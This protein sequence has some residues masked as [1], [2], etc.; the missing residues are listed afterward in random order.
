MNERFRTRADDWG[1]MGSFCGGSIK[2]DLSWIDKL[3]V[4]DLPKPKAPNPLYK[5]TNSSYGS[6]ASLA[7][8]PPKQFHLS[9]QFTKRF[10]PSPYEDTSLNTSRFRSVHPYP[11]HPSSPFTIY[12]P[13]IQSF[14]TQAL[15]VIRYIL[16][17]CFR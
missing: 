8:P 16:I 14:P 15:L 10:P 17:P 9:N 11:H 6:T 12:T 4:D 1:R 7:R 2:T 5:T 3:T 13:G